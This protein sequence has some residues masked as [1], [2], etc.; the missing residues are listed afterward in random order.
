[1]AKR[2]ETKG[3]GIG[4]REGTTFGVCAFE[5]SLQEFAG[6]KGRRM[7]STDFA[8]GREIRSSQKND[9]MAEADTSV[10]TFALPKI[11]EGRTWTTPDTAAR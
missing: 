5:M 10:P 9:Q 11:R 4:G 8:G 7:M 1:L 6:R 2:L 3:I